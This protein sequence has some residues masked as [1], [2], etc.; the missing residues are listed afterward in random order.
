MDE[1][2]HVH[3]CMEQCNKCNND[4]SLPEQEYAIQLAVGITIGVIYYVASNW[5]FNKEVV[6]EMLELLSKKKNKS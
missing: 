6:R 1:I 3:E 5:I 2:A 4:C